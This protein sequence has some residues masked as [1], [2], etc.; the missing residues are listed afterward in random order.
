MDDDEEFENIDDEY[1]YK[2]FKSNNVAQYRHTDQSESDVEI[3]VIEVVND[4]G[5]RN[6]TP[7]WANSKTNDVSR[8]YEFNQKQFVFDTMIETASKFKLKIEGVEGSLSYVKI[9]GS[10]VK[11]FN[12]LHLG[13]I[14]SSM[15]DIKNRCGNISSFIEKFMKI[16]LAKKMNSV[17]VDLKMILELIDSVEASVKSLE[18]KVKSESTQRNCLIKLRDARVLITN[19]I[20]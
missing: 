20:V 9:E 8:L 13:Q 6:I 4:T 1:N 17:N 2:K 19:E 11:A 5:N 12:E 14:V 10:Y 3:E 15:D 16:E 7:I 18:V